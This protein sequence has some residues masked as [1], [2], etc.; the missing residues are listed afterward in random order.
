MKMDPKSSSR[1]VIF[2]FFDKDGIADDYITEMLRG[3]R[4]N[5]QHILVVVNGY[6]RPDSR[7]RLEEV[8]D[9]V[10][11]RV[12]VGLDVG[13]YREGL[14]Y[15]G[16]SKLSEFDEIIL[17]NYTFFAPLFPF[18]EMFRTMAEKDIDFWGITKHHTVEGNPFSGMPYSY[19][20]EHINSHFIAMRKSLFM[21]FNYRNFIMDFRNPK[22]Y[23]QSITRYEAVFTKHFADLGFSWDVYMDTSEYEGIS[24]AP[25][26]YEIQDMIP[27][28]RC[29]IIKRRSFFTDYLAFLQNN[30]G[31]SSAEAY[32][33][34]RGNT[35]Y[36]TH[37]IWD[38][39]LRLQNLQD[40]HQAV[41]Q[42]YFLPEDVTEHVFRED[43]AAVIV[44]GS[45]ERFGVLTG[46]WG[47]PFHEKWKT[48]FLDGEE[49]Y[50]E[51]LIQA[52]KLAA[53]TEYACIVN[54]PDFSSG[55][56]PR[57]N[58]A[59]LFYREMENTAATEEF[60]G[61]V[62]D[63]F[64]EDSSLGMLIPPCS[65]F[66][67]WF[68]KMQDG[69]FGRFEDVKAAARNLGL[70]VPVK[71]SAVHPLVPFGGSFWIRS[72]ILQ[73]AAELPLAEKVPDDEVMRFLLP[74]LAQDRRFFTGIVMSCGYAAIEMTNQ[75]YRM[76][77]NNQTVFERFGPDF[78][79]FELQKIRGERP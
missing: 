60:T 72:E 37:L 34:I 73:A 75:D 12:N 3:L 13:G 29:P 52:G 48:V 67:S 69:W 16:F 20:P 64:E 7:M 23:I 53:G 74:Y 62:L 79:E 43:E 32:D 26:M 25:F 65:A 15:L 47:R 33:E 6:I 10:L 17:M 46:R 61:N 50:R 55:E 40:V 71:K 28:K 77:C 66:G 1:C 35:E 58:A 31:E 19:L 45:R 78:F 44:F 42:N 38:N 8:S 49:S 54:L 63:A 56:E 22:T 39:I 5:V 18:R 70:D 27:E 21:S 36:D 9:E 57:S 30:C 2:L 4:E 14:F 41:H 51:K 68:P 24:Y 76:R 59:S 11:S